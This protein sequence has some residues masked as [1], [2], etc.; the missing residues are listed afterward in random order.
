LILEK[1]KMPREV[2]TTETIG[3]RMTTAQLAASAYRAG[4]Y[5][6]QGEPVAWGLLPEVDRTAWLRVGRDAEGILSGLDG[7]T[8]QDAALE[9]LTTFLHGRLSDIAAPSASFAL[10]WQAVARHLTQLLDDEEI[11]DL[12]ALEQSWRVWAAKRLHAEEKQP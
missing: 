1:L 10:S 12:E 8:Y 11:E 4:T 6:S 2:N 7:K 5:A 9:L 3:E